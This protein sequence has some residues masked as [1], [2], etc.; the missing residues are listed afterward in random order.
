[1]ELEFY[2]ESSLLRCTKDE[3]IEHIFELRSLQELRLQ[4]DGQI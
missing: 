1:M 4:E 2:K 3:L